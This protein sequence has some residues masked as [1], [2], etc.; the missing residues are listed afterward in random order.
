M[1][2]APMR[3]AYLALTV[4]S[5]YAWGTL[6]SAALTPVAARHGMMVSS[7]ENASEAG[8][9]IMKAGG[10]AVDAVRIRSAGIALA[11]NDIGFIPEP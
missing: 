11:G 10:N 2:T 3:T 6:P 7:E 9:E 4:F 1:K 8:V 5:L